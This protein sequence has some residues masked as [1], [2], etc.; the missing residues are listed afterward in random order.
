MEYDFL[1]NIFC[2]YC[3]VKGNV[4]GKIS[5][6]NKNKIKANIANSQ[7]VTRNNIDLSLIG[8]LIH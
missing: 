3:F 5:K 1:W 8:I 7:L 6:E 4:I 2:F